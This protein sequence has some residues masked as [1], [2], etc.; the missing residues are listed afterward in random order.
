TGRRDESGIAILDE[1]PRVVRWNDEAKRLAQVVIARGG[2]VDNETR[3]AAAAVNEVG[4]P[5]TA[6]V[7]EETSALLDQGRLVVALGGDHSVPF[8]AI[9]AH[10]ERDPGL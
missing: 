10:A 9:R 6:W 2:A 5:L 7:Y 8:G 4:E 3:R 1:E